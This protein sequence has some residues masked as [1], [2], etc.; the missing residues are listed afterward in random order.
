MTTSFQ[1]VLDQFAAV[2]KAMVDVQAVSAG[3]GDLKR[4]F[5]T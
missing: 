2:Q 4:I 3:I 1:R 5:S